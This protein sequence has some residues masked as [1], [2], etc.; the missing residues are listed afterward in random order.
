MLKW[1]PGEPSGPTR[2]VYYSTA[3]HPEGNF[4]LALVVVGGEKRYLL[5][6][7]T[8][9]IGPP[10]FVDKRMAVAHAD[11]EAEAVCQE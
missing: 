1:V 2:Q 3:Y 10:W 8:T 4:T 11:R 9:K 6:R 7:G 5:H